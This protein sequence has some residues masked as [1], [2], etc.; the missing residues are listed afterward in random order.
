MP[1]FRLTKDNRRAAEATYAERGCGS[2]P[3]N[4]SQC[5]RAWVAEA[6]ILH[7]VGMAYG[8]LIQ[9]IWWYG[10][11]KLASIVLVLLPVAR[12]NLQSDDVTVDPYLDGSDLAAMADVTFSFLV[13]YAFVIGAYVGSTLTDLIQMPDP[14][15]VVMAVVAVIYL[16]IPAAWFW[17]LIWPAH[18]CM[19]S[20]KT[21]E[22]SRLDEEI[23]VAA[24]DTSTGKAGAV[25]RRRDLAGRRADVARSSTWPLGRARTGV[26]VAAGTA[27]LF[28]RN[29]AEEAVKL[30]PSTLR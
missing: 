28:P 11:A 15:L 5:L 27:S 18:Q 16:L 30:R 20:A 2:G 29:W 8:F 21:N 25:E 12:S 13:L 4:W 10:L 6:P 1:V 24:L 14:P 19:A 23:R 26:L 22:I 17:A 9:A 3:T 7:G